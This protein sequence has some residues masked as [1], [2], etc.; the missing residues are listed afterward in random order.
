MKAQHGDEIFVSKVRG[1]V[2]QEMRGERGTENARL[3]RSGESGE[4]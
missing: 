1:A 3:S 2:Y 4:R